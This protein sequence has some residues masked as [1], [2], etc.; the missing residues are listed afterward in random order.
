MSFVEE[1]A[2][3]SP[4]LIWLP[5]IVIIIAG[6]AGTFTCHTKLQAGQQ[7]EIQQYF[8]RFKKKNPKNYMNLQLKDPEIIPA[9]AASRKTT[10]LNN[11]KKK[12][13]WSLIGNTLSAKYGVFVHELDID[14]S[15]NMCLIITAVFSSTF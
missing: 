12:K 5:R 7:N 2:G 15:P 11:L 3:M 4:P 1:T 9:A 13:S 6:T 10:W 14:W 8:L